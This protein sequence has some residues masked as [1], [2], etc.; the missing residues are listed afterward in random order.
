MEPPSL[1]MVLEES[2]TELDALF[3]MLQYNV[4]KREL[5][6]YVSL[7]STKLRRVAK[8]VPGDIVAAEVVSV[9]SPNVK[10]RLYKQRSNVDPSISHEPPSSGKRDPTWGFDGHTLY[11]VH[12]PRRVPRLCRTAPLCLRVSRTGTRQMGVLA[13]NDLADDEAAAGRGQ[14]LL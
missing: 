6:T 13:T 8:D 14:G 11:V 12:G 5:T 2:A 1:P 4:A 9:H 3:G 10:P 7:E